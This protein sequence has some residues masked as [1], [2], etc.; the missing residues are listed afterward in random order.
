MLHS[1]SKGKNVCMCITYTT[2]IKKH[3]CVSVKEYMCVP[4]RVSC[5]LPFEPQLQCRQE[6]VDQGDLGS[7]HSSSPPPV[8]LTVCLLHFYFHFY[9]L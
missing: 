2:Y 1:Y 8:F 5:V 6:P 4:E 9:F 3:T 7:L